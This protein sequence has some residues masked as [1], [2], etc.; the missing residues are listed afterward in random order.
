MV[1][2]A[3]STPDSNSAQI[4]PWC[5]VHTPSIL[6]EFRE[7]FALRVLRVPGYIIRILYCRTDGRNTE[8]TGSMSSLAPKLPRVL[9]TGSIRPCKYFEY[10]Q[11]PQYRTP[12]KI[13]A[14]STVARNPTSTYSSTRCVISIEPGTLRVPT[15]STGCVVNI[16]PWHTASI[17]GCH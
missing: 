3:H 5:M 4:L 15:A 17:Q 9:A 13:Q 12:V 14:V 16:E 1:L 7:F 2:D 10:R 11:Y 6:A 8:S